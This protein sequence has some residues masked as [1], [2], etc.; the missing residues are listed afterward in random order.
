MRVGFVEK[1][2]ETRFGFASSINV[3]RRDKLLG[4]LDAS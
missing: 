1:M 3:H 2:F 4:E